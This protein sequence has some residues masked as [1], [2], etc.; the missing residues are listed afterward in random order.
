MV[1]KIHTMSAFSLPH[2]VIDCDSPSPCLHG[3]VCKPGTD[4]EDAVCL[5]KPGFTGDVCQCKYLY[6]DSHKKKVEEDKCLCV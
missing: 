4:T 2:L 5:C 1:P 3:G 6:L